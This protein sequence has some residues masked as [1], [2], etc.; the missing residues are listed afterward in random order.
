MLEAR[1]C[2]PSPY[3]RKDHRMW[4][5][6]FLIDILVALLTLLAGPY[7]VL[8]YKLR[9][10]GGI[11]LGLVTWIG[12][13]AIF[14]VWI[15]CSS[16]TAFLEG[17]VYFWLALLTLGYI[18]TFTKWCSTAPPR[19][20]CS[21]H[22]WLGRWEPA[23][24]LVISL[25]AAATG[26][27]GFAFFL[28]G[29]ACSTAEWLLQR[30]RRRLKAWTPQDTERLLAPARLAA[31]WVAS[32][33]PVCGRFL[34]HYGLIAASAL[35]FASRAVWSYLGERARQRA[36][37]LAKAPHAPGPYQRPPT[38]FGRVMSHIIASTVLSMI[39]SVI[40]F[41]IFALILAIPLWLMGW[42]VGLP[43]QVKEK[44]RSVLHNVRESL[45][46][47]KDELTERL[48]RKRE[49]ME[50]RLDD[51]R[52]SLRDGVDRAKRRAA[53]GIFSR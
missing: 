53:W 31:A 48:R 20:I 18:Q 27:G 51:A 44:A 40:G 8:A 45:E 33:S 38:F 43:G 52:D 3:E 37:A 36:A 1:L 17:P 9:S 28:A 16:E 7:R 14:P 50:D 34:V 23:L 24:A 4:F 12:T 35:A 21:P 13:A 25:A 19:D 47:E 41:N 26:P 46:D 15:A 2:I 32:T 10:F 39:T 22:C 6:C 29:Y 49:E 11:G 30:L 42:H 5:L